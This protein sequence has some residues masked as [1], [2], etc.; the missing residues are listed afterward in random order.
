[1]NARIEE[2]MIQA[3]ITTNLETDLFDDEG[4]IGKWLDHFAEEFAQLIVREC[5]SLCQ[6]SIDDGCV[7]AEEPMRKIKKHFGVE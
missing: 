2:L 7:E 5:M 4:N 1:M 3:G 6:E